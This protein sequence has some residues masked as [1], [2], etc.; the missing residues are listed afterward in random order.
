M[1]VVAKQ[2][3]YRLSTDGTLVCPISGFTTYNGDSVAFNDVCNHILSEHKLKCLHV[4]Q[5]THHG[6][7]GPW[8]DTIAVFG[9]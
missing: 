8:H 4:G 2:E 3:M 1:P 6:D 5:E 9:K 7:H